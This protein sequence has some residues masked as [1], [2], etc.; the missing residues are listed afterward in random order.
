M[1]LV[2][3]Q[4]AI[5]AVSDLLSSRLTS[6]TTANTVD[7]G[8]PEQA[9]SVAGPKFNLFLYQ[10]GVD[11]HM[12]NQALDRGQ[13]DPL[14]LVLHYVLTAFDTGPE[15]DSVAAHGL[16]GEGMLALH[17][18]NFLQPVAPELA[19]NPEPLKITFD[20]A[21]ADLLSKVLQGTDV[22][23]RL[24]VAF[25]VR[26]VM[27]APSV[28]PRYTLPVRTVGPP[29]SEGVIMLPSLGA[30]LTSVSPQRFTAGTAIT[31]MG[32]DVNAAITD[33]RIGNETLAVTSASEGQV[34]TTIP[35]ATG[36]SA[37]SYALCVSRTLVSGMVLSS[38]TL[39][40]QLLPDVVSATP[41]VLSN[42]AGMVSGDLN[43]A[44]TRLG[45]PDDAVFVAF[46]RDG[47]VALML[48]VTGTVAQ[49]SLVASVSGDDAIAAGNYFIIVRV[50][51][52]QAIDA[53]QV[54]WS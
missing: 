7:V 33:V 24:S 4:Q 46:Y 48:Q 3:S 21:D 40:V 8:R 50:N 29:G 12:R 38:D 5:G 30:R 36:L 25:Q 51:G 23:Y 17:E 2:N 42:N 19:D 47:D 52:V 11:G 35:L 13:A 43:I 22:Q 44:G 14:W 49:T 41:G 45:G 34:I 32:R 53:P 37:G 20:N 31:V 6:L 9:A 26:P 10:I 15:S 28:A 39:A 27:I 54:V 1:A 18:L 16:L